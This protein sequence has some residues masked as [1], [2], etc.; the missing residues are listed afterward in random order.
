MPL[1]KLKNNMEKIRILSE[2]YDDSIADAADTGS[3][4]S[5][6]KAEI[7]NEEIVEL[8]LENSISIR[9]LEKRLR[10]NLDG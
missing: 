7:A 9:T 4:Q 3:T 10:K 2:I 5:K 8:I 1:K 6:V